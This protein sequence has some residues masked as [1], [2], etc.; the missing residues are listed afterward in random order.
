MVIDVHAHL[1]P[2]RA[3]AELE[4]DPERFGIRVERTAEGHPRLQ[5]AGGPL[6]RPILPRIQDVADRIPA[7]ARAGVDRQILS[8]WLDLAAYNLDAERGGRWHRLVNETLAEAAN[9]YPESLSA[10]AVV[11]LQSPADAVRELGYAVGHLGMAGAIIGANIEG[12]DLDDPALDP[13]WKAAVE[14]AAPLLVHPIVLSP[15]PRTAD[16]FLNS[17]AAFLYDTTLAGAHLALGGVLDRHPD[18]KL[19]LVH[20]GGYLPYQAARLDRGYATRAETRSRCARPPSEYLK[21]FYYDTVLHSPL[22]LRYLVELVGAD[23]VLLGS[24]YPFDLGDPEPTRIVEASG[25]PDRDK[26]LILGE[27][28]RRL[29][30]L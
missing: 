17:M 19:I 10:L 6:L 7:M 21:A 29:F 12:K 11:P 3:L 5:A 1:V 4:R 22:A 26:R 15:S 25:L 16:Y 24:D 20:G 23:H 2:P 9:S 18:L 27:N 30:R 8:V 28:A 14:L 13:F